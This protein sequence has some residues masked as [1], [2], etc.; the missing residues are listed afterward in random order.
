MVAKATYERM[1]K[2]CPMPPDYQKSEKSVIRA[3]AR[4]AVY[5]GPA[6]R[7]QVSD[8]P[9]DKAIFSSGNEVTGFSQAADGPH[10]AER[11][12]DLKHPRTNGLPC[13]RRAGCI[14]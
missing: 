2:K 12:H 4:N 3:T 9:P 11:Q 14:D 8:W 1:I 5:G 13:Q 6:F 10:L 7:N